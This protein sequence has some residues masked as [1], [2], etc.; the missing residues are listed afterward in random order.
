MA[1]EPVTATAQCVKVGDVL[2]LLPDKEAP[3]DHPDLRCYSNSELDLP[4]RLVVRAVYVVDHTIL[5]SFR[6]DPRGL[7][8]RFYAIDQSPGRSAS[9]D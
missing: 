9:S 4:D 7:D 5:L 2:G 8:R 3:Q 6:D 1:D